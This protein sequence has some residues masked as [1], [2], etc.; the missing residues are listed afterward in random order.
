MEWLGQI[1]AA[2]RALEGVLAAPWFAPAAASA[3][4]V[5]LLLSLWLLLRVRRLKRQLAASADPARTLYQAVVTTRD[6]RLR[7]ADAAGGRAG[8]GQAA[9]ALAG[10][11]DIGRMVD[12]ALRP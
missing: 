7:A 9:S 8:E 10:Q 1:S 3:L 6:A 5:L 4:A 12:H 2:W 11:G